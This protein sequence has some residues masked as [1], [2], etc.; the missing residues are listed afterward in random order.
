MVYSSTLLPQKA[1]EEK[2]IQRIDV[3][4]ARLLKCSMLSNYKAEIL[5]SL[6][7]RSKGRSIDSGP[8][9]VLS[10]MSDKAMIFPPPSID[11]VFDDSI[12]ENVKKVWKRIMGDEVDDSEFLKFDE[13]GAEDDN[14]S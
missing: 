6:K 14:E 8:G 5:W 4:L 9:P 3:A 12:L 1:D 2:S 13:R 11:P 10:H 7:Y